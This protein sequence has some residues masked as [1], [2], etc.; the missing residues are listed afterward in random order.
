MLMKEDHGL[1]T[2]RHRGLLASESLIIPKVI[3]VS[4]LLEE[5]AALLFK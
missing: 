4:S 1:Y 3:R 2:G 5:T